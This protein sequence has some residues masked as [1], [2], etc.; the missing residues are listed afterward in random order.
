LRQSEETGDRDSDCGVLQLT[1]ASGLH[2]GKPDVLCLWPLTDVF[3]LKIHWDKVQLCFVRSETIRLF[4]LYS[5]L[6]GLVINEKKLDKICALVGYYAACNGNS[7]PTFRDNLSV[8]SWRVKKSKE[9][10]PK[11]TKNKLGRIEVG[12]CVPE[13][14]SYGTSDRHCE[15]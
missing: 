12:S 3:Q 7:S 8:P 15:S 1:L 11:I 14:V 6:L 10:K 4:L 9:R 13:S 2:W 5:V